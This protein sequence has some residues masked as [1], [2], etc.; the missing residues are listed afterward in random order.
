MISELFA[1]YKSGAKQ[2]ANTRDDSDGLLRLNSVHC[3]G[4]HGLFVR[5]YLSGQIVQELL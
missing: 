1:K 4:I 5:M 2:C 3:V